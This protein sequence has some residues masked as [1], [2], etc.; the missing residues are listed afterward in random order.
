MAHV[1]AIPGADRH[2]AIAWLVARCLPVGATVRRRVLAAEDGA[3]YPWTPCTGIRPRCLQEDPMRREAHDPID[4]EPRPRR[5]RPLGA[6]DPHRIV[7]AVEGDHRA[8][9]VGRI[10]GQHV[11]QL[12]QHH[13]GRGLLGGR[14]LGGR[15]LGG[16]GWRTPGDVQW[17]HPTP[18]CLGHRHQPVV[19]PPGHDPALG[20]ARRDPM[21]VRPLGAGPRLGAWPGRG[22]AHPQRPQQL[23]R[24]DRRQVPYQQRAHHVGM[25]LP[26]GQ[27]VGHTGPP[28][29]EPGGQ[30]Q[31]RQRLG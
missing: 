1:E 14:L 19:L 27:P 6:G 13:R 7:V 10:V 20:H 21:A 31:P 29:A 24:R 23:P 30:A 18:L 2:G 5:W 22:V 3:M 8:W 15:L 12:A 4:G 16:R 28:A 17:Q 9:R 25:H 11:P 26:A